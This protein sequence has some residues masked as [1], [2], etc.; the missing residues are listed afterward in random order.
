MLIDRRRFVRASAAAG[1]GLLF[2]RCQFGESLTASAL[3]PAAGRRQVV[4]AGRRV[5][6]IDMHSHLFVG[7]VLPLLKDRKEA[8]PGLANLARSPMAVDAATIARRLT[9]M[10]R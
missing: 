1:G 7:D 2:C 3:Q 4:I 8:D 10:D 6:T 5:R 9:D